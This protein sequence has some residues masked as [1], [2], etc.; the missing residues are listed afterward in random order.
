MGHIDA[1]R[2]HLKRGPLGDQLVRDAVALRLMAAIEAVG[3]LDEALLFD[4]IGGTWVQ[5][6]ATR[7]ILAHDYE[8]LELQTLEDTVRGDLDEFEAGIRRLLGS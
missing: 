5:I 1:L 8:G 3:R 2:A 6:R 4:A 7:N